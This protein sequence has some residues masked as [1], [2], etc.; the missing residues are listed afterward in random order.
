MSYKIAKVCA[1]N[2]QNVDLT[3][4]V[5][6]LNPVAVESLCRKHDV[7]LHLE[8]HALAGLCLLEAAKEGVPTGDSLSL[9]IGSWLGVPALPFVTLYKVSLTRA[10]TLRS[11]EFTTALALQ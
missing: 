3:V 8:G 5:Q 2:F 4:I 6:G 11:S 1:Q 10:S 9:T 7:W